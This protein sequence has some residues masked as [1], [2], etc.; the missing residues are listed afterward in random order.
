MCNFSEVPARFLEFAK[1]F[2]VFACVMPSLSVC[3]GAR[4][5]TGDVMSRH[6]DRRCDLMTM[7]TQV[8]EETAKA[9]Q[10]FL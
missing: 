8:Q 7:Q 4:W 10:V 9:V 5:Y 2:S 3:G 1:V 6:N